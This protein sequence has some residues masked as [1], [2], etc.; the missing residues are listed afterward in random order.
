MHFLLS[1]KMEARIV[2]PSSSSRTLTLLKHPGIN[3]D[4]ISNSI[5]GNKIIKVKLARIK[6]LNYHSGLIFSRVSL[7]ELLT[8]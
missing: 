8:E 6:I 1:T 7:V 4:R 2:T 5:I 3:F